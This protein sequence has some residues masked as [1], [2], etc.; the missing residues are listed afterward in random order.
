MDELSQKADEFFENGFNFNYS[1]EMMR[2]KAFSLRKKVG[3]LF[4]TYLSVLF[5]A[6]RESLLSKSSEAAE[7]L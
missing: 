1:A 2:Y 7:R 5:V 3:A 4:Y 6:C